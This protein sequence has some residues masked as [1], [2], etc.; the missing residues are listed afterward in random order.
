MRNIMTTSEH[1]SL[2]ES[3]FWI[4]REIQR[5]SSRRR[6]SP[7]AMRWH[8]IS[9]G[10]PSSRRPP[11][12]SDVVFSGTFWTSGWKPA[13]PLPPWAPWKPHRDAGIAEAPVWP[14]PARQLGQKPQNAPHHRLNPAFTPP[15]SC[16][17]AACIRV[18]SASRVHRLVLPGRWTSCTQEIIIS[19]TSH[20]IWKW[21][22][23]HDRLGFRGEN[24]SWRLHFWTFINIKDAVPSEREKM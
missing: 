16:S 19:S 1:A 13:L 15:F 20:W 9:G 24:V 5:C 14:R 22:K 8:H 6:P 17:D 10:R 3:R 18:Q 21:S 11:P 2:I 7:S 23:P 4:Q 12:S